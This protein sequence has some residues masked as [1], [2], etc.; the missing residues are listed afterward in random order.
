MTDWP[1]DMMDSPP[2]D[3]Q[4]ARPDSPPEL[5]PAGE[6]FAAEALAE[7]RQKQLLYEA[8]RMEMMS[9]VAHY[10]W[11]IATM[12]H[13]GDKSQPMDLAEDG[14]WPFL[15]EIFQS[16]ATDLVLVGAAGNGKTEFLFVDMIA[17]AMLGLR[18]G[19]V[20]DTDKKKD[21]VVGS[22]WDP[23]LHSV[24]FYRKLME[25]S[26][27]E[28]SA[29]VDSASFKHIGHGSVNA[30]GASSDISFTSYR[31]DAVTVDE[32][33]DCEPENLSKLF[34][35]MTGADW[36]LRVDAGHPS[37]PGTE[38]N[39]NLDWLFQKS[40]QRFWNVPC[41]HCG[42]YQV[43]DWWRHFVRVV[44]NDYGAVL[45]VK[46]LDPEWH[47]NAAVEMRP[48]CIQ[49]HQPM[50]RLSRH[51]KWVPRAPGRRAR[52]YS[53]SNL[54]NPKSHMNRM[55]QQYCAA[56]SN[57][58]LLR[59]FINRQLGLPDRAT[60]QKI[61]EEMLQTASTCQAAGLEPYALVPA[62]TIQWR[63]A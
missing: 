25:A 9:R 2:T 56:L 18:C 7:A 36:W 5:P 55:Y 50:I 63:A 29:D 8:R 15:R 32:H 52:G 23:T 3:A 14:D 41:P 16:D 54:Y 21:K 1:A 60:G 34:D 4:E 48:M 62:R 51:G 19:Y 42:L 59:L 61:T 53:L 38:Q 10:R 31:F 57:P 46:P 30:I 45:S 11:Q 22:R 37:D 43:M 6:A 44:R 58:L 35:R 33:Q 20:F 24:G 26:K 39:K 12:F 17:K 27:A 40:D 49:C 28:R 13:R 47:E